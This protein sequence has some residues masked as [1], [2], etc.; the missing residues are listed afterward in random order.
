MLSGPATEVDFVKTD[1]TSPASLDAAFKKPWPSSVAALPL[2]IFHTAAVIIPSDRSK[3][4]YD[5]PEAVNVRGTDNVLRAAR[6]AGAD[7]FSSTSSGSIAIRPIGPWVAPWA[8]SPKEFWQVLDEKDFFE[9]LRPHE[10]FF[11]NYPASKA[12]AER[13][14]CEANTDGFQTGCIR[15]IN[16]VYGNPT[17]NTVGE[18]LSRSVL[19]T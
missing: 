19:P 3:H 2:T 17:D 18:P 8:Q 7:I 1:I 9:P 4:F 16:G 12:A 14:V 13:L 5:F 6:K 11:G 10:Q 15:P